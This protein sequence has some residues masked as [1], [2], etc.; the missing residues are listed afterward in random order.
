MRAVDTEAVHRPADSVCAVHSRRRGARPATVPGR[1]VC[2]VGPAAGPGRGATVNETVATLVGN[3]ASDVRTTTSQAGVADQQLPGGVHHPAVRARAR[4]LGRRRHPVR[5]RR[6]LA[7]ARRARGRVAEPRATRWSC[8]AASG[9]AS[10]RAR[11]AAPARPSS[12]RRSTAGH[13]LSR[14]VSRFTR[15]GRADAER[16]GR[17]EADELA[18]RVAREARRRADASASP[19]SAPL[20]RTPLRG[21]RRRG[22]RPRTGRREQ[23]PDGTRLDHHGGVHL[24]HAAGRARRTATR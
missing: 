16:P 20:R 17:S 5:H 9:C 11:T 18:E 19:R 2:G 12:S 14:G 6:V 13:D 4:W 3:V 22:R 10:G 23:P 8:T 24:H 21:R 7:L 15:H 1:R